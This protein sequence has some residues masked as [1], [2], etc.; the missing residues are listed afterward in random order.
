MLQIL[1]KYYLTPCFFK[2]LLDMG[3]CEGLLSAFITESSPKRAKFT[4]IY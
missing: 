4:I 2:I 3:A 1:K